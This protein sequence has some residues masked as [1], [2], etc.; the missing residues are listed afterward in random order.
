MALNKPSSKTL[1]KDT[2]NGRIP[3]EPESESVDEKERE[4]GEEEEEEEIELEKLESEVKQMA[5]KIME[6]RATLPDH[7]KTLLASLLSSQRPV[8]LHSQSGLDAGPS[9]ESNPGSEGQIEFSR[10]VPAEDPKT[11]KR[12]SLLKEKISSNISAVPVVLQ[13]MK[14]CI[15]RIDNLDA[16][17]G[18]IHPAFKRKRTC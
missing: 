7:F 15:S 16:D 10:Q 4:E 8:F 1:S 2:E 12:V 17:N 13:R 14:E 3:G 5:K 18:I 11:A 6:Y 9:G